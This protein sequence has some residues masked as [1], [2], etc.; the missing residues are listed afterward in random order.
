MTTTSK[1]FVS[2]KKYLN[3]NYGNIYFYQ[4]ITSQTSL[5]PYS[6]INLLHQFRLFWC[7]YKEKVKT[8]NIPE[9]R[10]GEGG[11]RRGGCGCVEQSGA[12][13]RGHTP[14][15]RPGPGLVSPLAT[16]LRHWNILSRAILV[17]LDTRY[18]SHQ[19][20]VSPDTRY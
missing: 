4:S 7:S 18:L 3:Q 15:T 9:A 13:F 20:F 19:I 17:T 11:G 8:H 12:T 1:K 5:I 16:Y 14:V 10:Y 6:A 2:F